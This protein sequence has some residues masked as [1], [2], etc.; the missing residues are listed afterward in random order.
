MAFILA[1]IKSCFNSLADLATSC[2]PFT[3]MFAQIDSDGDSYTRIV[4]VKQLEETG[5]LSRGFTHLT[6]SFSKRWRGVIFGGFAG[7]EFYQSSTYNYSSSANT[8][9]SGLYG[10]EYFNILIDD[11]NHYQFGEY[12]VSLQD[13]ALVNSEAVVVSG[14][15]VTTDL[16]KR[17]QMGLRLG[18]TKVFDSPFYSEATLSVDLPEFGAPT[19]A[20]R[21]G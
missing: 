14:L 18:Y 9:Y 1:S 15:L 7:S 17:T 3:S 8:K 6:L 4:R 2:T 10:A 11:P 20:A 13:N 5:S 21:N 19:N 16:S 12:V